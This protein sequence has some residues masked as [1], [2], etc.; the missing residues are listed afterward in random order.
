MIKWRW[1]GLCVLGITTWMV[2]CASEAPPDPTT[3]TGDAPLEEAQAAPQPMPEPTVRDVNR[4]TLPSYAVYSE[5]PQRIPT[6]ELLELRQS[7]PGALHLDEAFGVPSLLWVLHTPNPFVEAPRVPAETGALNASAL[8]RQ[9]DVARDALRERKALYRLTDRDIDSALSETVHNTGQ[10][11]LIVAFQQEREGIPV[12]GAS[13]RVALSPNGRVIALSGHLAEGV[14]DPVSFKDRFVLSELRALRFAFAE[15]GLAVKESQLLAQGPSGDYTAYQ[16]AEHPQHAL[17]SPARAR[18]VFFPVPGGLV[19]AYDIELH[20]QVEGDAAPSAFRMV[21]SARDGALLV[22]HSM[23][24][25]ESFTYRVYADPEGTP[26]DG[27]LRNTAKP[28]MDGTE[29]QLLDASTITLESMNDRGDAWLPPGSTETVGNHVDA[30]YDTTQPDGLSGQERR[31]QASAA[32]E[33]D[34]TYDHGSQPASNAGQ[35]YAPIIQMFYVNNV[36]HDTYY[37]HGF[38]EEAGNAQQDNYDRGGFGRDRINAETL[39]FS[40]TNNASMFTPADGANPVMQMFV[41]DQRYG[42]RLELSG[43][44]SLEDTYRFAPRDQPVKGDVSGEIVA[45]DDGS[46]QGSDGCQSLASNSL[47]GQIALVDRGSCTFLDKVQIAEA[48]GAV[49]VIIANNEPQDPNSLG[50]PEMGGFDAGESL[51][52]VLISYADGQAIRAALG[53]TPSARLKTYMW[54]DAGLDSDTVAH[55]WHHYMFG[56]LTDPSFETNQRGSVNEGNSDFGALLLVVREADRQIAGN[57]AYQAAYPFSQYPSLWLPTG[58]RRAAYSTDTAVNP[59]TYRHISDGAALPDGV[60]SFGFG[61]TNS[62]VHNAGEIWANAMWGCYVSLLNAHSFD[63]ARTRMLGYHVAA[64]KMFPAGAHFL[65]ARDAVLVAMAAGDP[66]DFQRCYAAFTDRGMGV[67]AIAPDR[68]SFTHAGLRESFDL[69]GS[70]TA[71]ASIAELPGSCDNDGVLDLGEQAVITV[72]V[73]NTGSEPVTDIRVSASFPSVG[74]PNI[75]RG[76]VSFPSG[77]EAVIARLGAM[78][79]GEATLTVQLDESLGAD[80]L[81]FRANATGVGSVKDGLYESAVRVNVDEADAVATYDDVE[82]EATAWTSEH[83]VGLSS[84]SWEIIEADGDRRWYGPNAGAK[85][86]VYLISPELEVAA[87]AD[88]V[89]TFSHRYSFESDRRYGYD[90]GVVEISVD[91]GSSWKDASEYGAEPGYTVRIPDL[92]ELGS[93]SSDNNP[94][95]GRLAFGARSPLFPEP[96]SV[97]LDF[98]RALGGETAHLRFRIGTD[99][100]TA[101]DGWEIDDLIFQGLT[102][103]PFPA[104]VDEDGLC[105]GAAPIANAGADV[106]VFEGESVALDGSMSRAP[107]TDPLTYTWTQTGGPEVN[108][109]GP[110]SA[111]PGFTAPEVEANT[112][113]TFELVVA[114]ATQTSVPDSITVLVRNIPVGQPPENAPPVAVVSAPESVDAGALFTLDGSASSDPEGQPL[115]YFW[116]QTGGPGVTLTDALAPTVNVTAPSLERGAVLT[117]QLVVS[118]GARQSAPVQV[119]VNVEAGGVG[120]VR[121]GGCSVQPGTPSLPLG[122]SLALGLGLVA[123]GRLRSRR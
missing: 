58:A 66:Q 72:K 83:N 73:T 44:A 65:E 43:S 36:L 67:G 30:Y 81:S 26:W 52:A 55:E 93:S 41:Y 114:D 112:A 79:E 102:N 98:G 51:P 4:S 92:G 50:L 20:L 88:F 23:I 99:A 122:A 60:F 17:R 22:R 14:H 108:L 12:Y 18:A 63:E 56:R 61:A 7:A 106:D 57:D 15:A 101:G 21:I 2:S 103:T 3:Q 64:L 116:V 71:T 82:P 42:D 53:D 104:L 38:D 16:L 85:S 89:V 10:G 69:G 74:N 95:V 46:G 84:A 68:F 40:G 37:D 24:H 97:R 49:G 11:P 33:F 13:T 110:D 94:L 25:H 35:A 120:T 105:D 113:L 123:L 100:G 9:R 29:L 28:Y 78:E 27:P 48:A 19:P 87:D 96:N 77:D 111:S 32:G 34:Y 39:D 119:T 117:F 90:G 86:D 121:G 31:A 91:G 47:A 62:E 8:A 109:S 6:P 80:L 45:V 76:G 118:D 115:S 70:L 107:G 1:R 5:L 54:Q 75:D 59:L